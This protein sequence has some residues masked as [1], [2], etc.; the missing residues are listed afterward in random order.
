MTH[1]GVGGIASHAHMSG[2]ER[3]T[4]LLLA[5]GTIL[6]P[7]QIWPVMPLPGMQLSDVFFALAFIHFLWARFDIP[8]AVVSV[9]IAAFAAG[10]AASTLL[11]GSPVKLL[12]HF[13]LA[14]L[15][16]MA[17]SASPHGARWLRRALVI[18]AALAALTAMAALAVFFSGI[19]GYDAAGRPETPLLYIHGSLVPGNYPRPRGTLVSGAMLTSVVATGLV[20]LWC[21]RELVA[22]AWLRRA[23]HAI[24]LTAVFFAFSRTIATLAFVLVAAGLWR[25]DSPRWAR[26]AFLVGAAAY[27]AALWVSLRHH[28]VLNPM[29]PWAVDVLAADGDRFGR[30]RIAL[31][32]IAENPI[33]GAGPGAVIADGWSA[34]N[35]WLNLW[36]VLGIVPLAAF[37]F[38]M[39]AS[40]RAAIGWPSLGVAFALIFFL[41]ESA[42]NDIEDM[43]HVWLLIGIALGAGP[44]AR[45][46]RGIRDGPGLGRDMTGR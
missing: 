5:V 25:R 44:N 3:H 23:I 17:A 4:T 41:I 1:Q 14:A 19:A 35:T 8:P 38:L 36:A 7:L 40:I 18:A 9:P 16:W 37:A 2:R 43:R 30:W 13:E 11:G 42:Y 34:H 10:A 28:I 31:A 32:S 12:G 39:F 45:A 6:L 20:L 22:S 46:V 15:G 27:S 29:E 24:G 33:V 21:E 26:G